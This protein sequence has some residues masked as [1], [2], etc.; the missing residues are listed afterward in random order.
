M[1][2]TF[3]YHLYIIKYKSFQYSQDVIQQLVVWKQPPSDIVESLETYSMH[4][5]QQYIQ[6]S[7][8]RV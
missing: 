5:L 8:N 2:N 6:F 7:Q 4:L 1:I 3:Y